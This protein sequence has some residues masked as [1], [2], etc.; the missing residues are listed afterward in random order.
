MLP[1]PEAALAEDRYAFVREYL[2]RLPV[3]VEEGILFDVGAGALTMRKDVE[4]AGYA[5][6]GFDLHPKSPEVVQWDINTPFKGNRRA[7]IVLLMDVLE[8]TYNP[9]MA[10][11]NI[12]NILKPAGRIVMTMP[13]PCWSRARTMHLYSGYLACFTQHDLDANH[14]VFAPWPH[15]MLKLIQDCGLTLERY[16]TLDRDEIKKK[17]LGLKS[18][19]LAVE[20]LIRKTIEIRD[21]TARGMS[22][23]FV[24]R[25]RTGHVN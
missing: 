8:H 10:M 16:V 11:E 6:F 15:I 18:P 13:N 3:P 22:Y 25:P 24:A 9:G 4:E 23:A 5:W 12:A 2:A 17:P 20:G 7:D 19:I 1:S 21:P 14:H